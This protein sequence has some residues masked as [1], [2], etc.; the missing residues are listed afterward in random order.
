VVTLS[1]AYP[2][3]AM[4]VPILL[5]SGWGRN[6]TAEGRQPWPLSADGSDRQG[7]QSGGP[8]ASRLGGHLSGLLPWT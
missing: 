4:E 8:S 1:A 3:L 7:S 2:R 6:G 5:V